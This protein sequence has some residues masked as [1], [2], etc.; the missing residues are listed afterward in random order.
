MLATDQTLNIVLKSLRHKELPAPPL[1]QACAHAR[2]S[3]NL[4]GWD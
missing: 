4:I 2:W 1:S 3:E